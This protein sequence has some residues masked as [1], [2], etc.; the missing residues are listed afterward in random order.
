[1][2]TKIFTLITYIRAHKIMS[3]VV[4]ILRVGFAKH[5]ALIVWFRAY[6]KWMQNKK[7]PRLRPT[8][9]VVHMPKSN[10]TII[11]IPI[12]EWCLLMYGSKICVYKIEW[13]PKVRAQGVIIIQAINMI[14][15]TYKATW[16]AQA[17]LLWWW[18]KYS[19]ECENYESNG[20]EH[21]LELL[22][23]LH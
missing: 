12:F 1:M 10:I 22:I 18:L 14:E 8:Y 3:K 19:Y 15:G 17:C 5:R 7:C 2:K 9:L 16:Y 4:N 20:Y 11:W 6:E 13:T 21:D 23:I